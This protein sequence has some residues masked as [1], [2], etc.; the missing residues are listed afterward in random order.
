MQ[1][2]VRINKGMKAILSLYA[3][4]AEQAVQAMKTRILWL[5]QEN[6]KLK[7]ISDALQLQNV[8]PD[9]KWSEVPQDLEFWKKMKEMLNKQTRELT[10]QDGGL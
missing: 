7:A 6:S 9:K 2:V 3:D 1:S 8:T 5:E 10:G 4:D